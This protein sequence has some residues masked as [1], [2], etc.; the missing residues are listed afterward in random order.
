MI[1]KK[2]ILVLALAFC[3]AATLFVVTSTGYDPWVDQDE[4]G[5][6]DASDLN[7]L[8]EEYGSTGD[9]TKN[10]SVTNWPEPRGELFPETLVLRGAK[11]LLYYLLSGITLMTLAEE[12]AVLIDED[13]PLPPFHHATPNCTYLGIVTLSD[14]EDVG[15][16]GEPVNFTHEA[17][18]QTPYVIQGDVIIRPTLEYSLYNYAAS[19]T[20]FV[21]NVTVYFE[22]V[23]LAAVPTVLHSR[24]LRIDDDVIASSSYTQTYV[25]MG[26]RMKFADPVVVEPGERLRIRFETYSSKDQLNASSWIRVWHTIGS[27]EFIAHVPIYQP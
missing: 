20:N 13:T 8:A 27:D 6:V 23:D 26:F 4:D 19:T 7:V 16:A 25:H 10:V 17:Y 24:T 15:I 22:K 18:A 2:H 5:D 9:P 3:L 1:K 21:F 12:W 11:P 14:P